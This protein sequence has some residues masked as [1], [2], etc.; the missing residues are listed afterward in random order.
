MSD[1]QETYIL[2][3]ALVR[4]VLDRHKH[5]TDEEITRLTFEIAGSVLTDEQYVA[6]RW[7]GMK[8]PPGIDVREMI[9]GR[10]GWTSSRLPDAIVG[11]DMNLA[12]EDLLDPK[13]HKLGPMR[14]IGV[15]H[16]IHTLLK[17]LHGDLDS[18]SITEG[19]ETVVSLVGLL[20]PAFKTLSPVQIAVMAVAHDNAGHHAS[21]DFWLDRV[22]GY[23]QGWMQPAVT[24]NTLRT[25]VAAL[26]AAGFTVED[27]GAHLR[28]PTTMVVVSVKRIK[29][30]TDTL[31][32]K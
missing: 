9:I 14:W 25:E 22:N 15:F 32:G 13:N 18:Q 10:D 23:L 1:K 12:E 21:W 4:A 5:A 20:K 2:T 17:A 7:P 3:D 6:R 27:D 26:R 11:I 24:M 8:I 30:V 16:L 19:W 28:I 31:R 29:T